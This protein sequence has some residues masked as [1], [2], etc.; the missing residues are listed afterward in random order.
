MYSIVENVLK[1][2]GY[3]LADII[4]KIESLW[5][6]GSLTDD[7]KDSLLSIARNGAKIEN[8]LD[9]LAKFNDLE[10]R[11]RLLE[12]GKTDGEEITEY[13][14]GKWYYTGD[15]ISFEGES[16][17]CIAPEGIVCV[18]SP[19]DYPAYWEKP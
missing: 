14:S 3:N 13:V 11:V 8:S 15:K 4:R 2:G 1:Q 9:V 19:K 6:K 12:D 17:M 7:E 5:V 18:W 10:N 16:Y